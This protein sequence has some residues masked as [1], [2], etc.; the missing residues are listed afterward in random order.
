[1]FKSCIS[2]LKNSKENKP[3]QIQSGSKF[4][5]IVLIMIPQVQGTNY[6]VITKER[7]HSIGAHCIR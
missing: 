3:A 7:G 2:S 6:K 4:F 1:M 5:Q